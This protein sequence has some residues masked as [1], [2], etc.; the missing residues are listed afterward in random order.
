MLRDHSETLPKLERNTVSE[1]CTSVAPLVQNSTARPELSAGEPD[2][3]RAV[4][5]LVISVFRNELDNIPARMETTWDRLVD[6]LADVKPT[7]CTLATCARKDCPRKKIGAWSPA[8]WPPGYTR[9][10]HT[11]EAVCCLVVDLDHVPPAELKALLDRLAGYAYVLHASHS[12][13]SD[14]RCV[15]VVVQLTRPVLGSEFSGFWRAAVDQLEVPADEAAKDASRLYFLPSRPS[16]ACGNELD[17]SGFDHA[18]N[19]GAPIDVDAMLALVPSATPRELA[20]VVIPAFHRSPAPEAFTAAARV[21][22]KAWPNRGRHHAQLALAGALTRAGWPVELVAEFGAAV[23]EVQEPGN[24]SLEKRLA[25]A[26]DSV[27]RLEGGEAVS[28]WPTI[29]E[30]VDLAA[31]DTAMAMLGLAIA[32]DPDFAEAMTRAVSASST[33]A[34]SVSQRLGVLVS[35]VALAPGPPVRRY[36]TG[37]P[38]LDQLIGGG[39]TTRQL[40]VMMAPP[41]D[42]KSALA[43]SIA[44]HVQH[45]IPVLYASTELETAEVTARIAA[46]II[47]CAWRDIVDGHVP[48]EKV[49]SAV[50]GLRI[51]VV[52]S[53]MLPMG[54]AALKALSDEVEAMTEEYGVAPLLCLDYLQD[55]ARGTDERGVRAKIGDLAMKL[56]VMSQHLDC[57][58]LVVSSVSRT[59]YGVAK[60]DSMRKADDPAVYLAAAKESGDVDY[61]AAVVMFLDVLQREQGADHRVARIAIAKSRHGETGFV[62]A[63]FY[64]ATGRWTSGPDDMLGATE[65]RKATEISAR[66]REDDEKVFAAVVA[67]AGEQQWRTP[68]GWRAM[69]PDVPEKRLNASIARL[70]ASGGQ[71]TTT[72]THPLTKT[73]ARNH[74]VYVVLRPAAE[75]SQVAPA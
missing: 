21:L 66:D 41:G 49:A 63:R 10:K 23:A 39:I 32:P 57:A 17:G 46:P 3:G 62:G 16:D 53:E 45:S 40:A 14:G 34:T 2:P 59:Y 58:V 67:L 19:T 26:R 43:V 69:V 5:R 37:M 31:V 4:D 70:T 9:E 30:H 18:E 73:V 61:A 71:L 64:G 20:P 51:W 1:G 56:R 38:E 47:G 15:R 68:N 28:G 54:E 50:A 11:V 36:A 42:G 48:R 44:S 25:A 13:R 29:A 22:G 74:G 27:K 6:S 60:A 72:D 8:C 7:A 75:P 65:R 55:L 12:D 33:R 24:G 52:G 35:E